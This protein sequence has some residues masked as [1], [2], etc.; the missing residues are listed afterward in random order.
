MAS[1]QGQRGCRGGGPP[2][3]ARIGCCCLGSACQGRPPPLP[4]RARPGYCRCGWLGAVLDATG[5][6]RHRRLAHQEGRCEDAKML[7]PQNPTKYICDVVA[8]I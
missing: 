8:M 5:E 7:Y 4:V 6:Q 3:P 1:G 2:S